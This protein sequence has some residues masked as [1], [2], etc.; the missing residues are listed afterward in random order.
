MKA[1][2]PHCWRKIG[3]YGGDHSCVLI[4]EVHHCRNCQVF[5]EA[6]RGAF[7]VEAEEEE[8]GHEFAPAGEAS[9]SLLVFRLGESWLGLPTESLAE[10]A[11]NGAVRRV[12]HRSRGALE[13]LVAVRGELHLCVSLL[14]RFGLGQREAQRSLASA[15]LVLVRDRQ[16]A[17]L[18]FRADQV[19]GLRSAPLRAIEAPPE[20]LPEQ[21]AG[22]IEGVL[23]LDRLRVLLLNGDAVHTSLAAGLYA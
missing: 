13:G 11:A 12:A 7:A 6:A 5:Q 16:G 23:P 18:A 3:V 1:V 22:C 10:L 15:R 17:L 19:L 2:M 14:E 4:A 8:A 9:V 20:T 21:L